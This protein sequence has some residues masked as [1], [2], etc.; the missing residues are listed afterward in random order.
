MAEYPPVAFHFRVRFSISQED[1]DIRFQDVSGLSVAL[2]VEE[3]KEGGENRFAHRLPTPATYGNLVLK[4]GLLPDSAVRAWIEKAVQNFEFEPAEI[5]I[6]LLND[7]HE[8]I[9][10]WTFTRAWP[11]K[12]QISDLKSTANEVVIETLEL[13][14]ASFRQ[15]KK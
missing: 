7:Q 3:V 2:G 1:R 10:S 6:D 9:S 5:N 11:I 15:V 4:R 8:P 13:A 12:W 14:Y